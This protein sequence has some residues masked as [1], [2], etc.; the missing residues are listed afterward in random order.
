MYNLSLNSVHNYIADYASISETKIMVA[1]MCVNRL[2]QMVS[3]LRVHCKRKPNIY[4]YIF[5]MRI[6]HSL[7]DQKHLPHCV[8]VSTM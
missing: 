4:I 7:D 5:S 3:P 6:N 1:Y 8:C 2:G